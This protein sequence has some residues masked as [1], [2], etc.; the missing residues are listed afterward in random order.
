MRHP[1]PRVQEFP[2]IEARYRRSAVARL[3]SK[4]VWAVAATFVG[5]DRS[6]QLELLQKVRTGRIKGL[7]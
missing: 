3:A 6:M 1:F 2:D 5:T 7:S 4:R